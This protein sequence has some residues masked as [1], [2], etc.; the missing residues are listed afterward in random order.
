MAGATQSGGRGL[1]NYT[2]ENVYGE[3]L[4]GVIF[5]VTAFKAVSV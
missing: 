5:H 3:M 2:S 4:E 1:N